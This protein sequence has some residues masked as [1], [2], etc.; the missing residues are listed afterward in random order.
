METLIAF[1]L[2]LVGCGFGLRYRYRIAKW[3][4]LRITEENNKASKIITLNRTI[5]DAQHELDR[6]EREEN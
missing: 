2:L 4:K 3:L 5:E 6:L 1:G